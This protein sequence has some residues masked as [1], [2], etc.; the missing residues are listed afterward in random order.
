MKTYKECTIPVNILGTPYKLIICPDDKD[1]RFKDLNCAGFCDYSVKKLVISNFTGSTDKN[2]SIEDVR[3]IIR[4]AILHEM[5]HAYFYESGLGE[6]WEHKEFGQE[7]TVVDWIA[8]Q[9]I[10]MNTTMNYIFNE[11]EKYEEETL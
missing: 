6:D 5:V 10:K 4:K 9:L 11:L 1:H 8:R 7:E 2:V 3:Y